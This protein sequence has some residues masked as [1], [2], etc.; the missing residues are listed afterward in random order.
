MQ[1]MLFDKGEPSD[2]PRDYIRKVGPD[3]YRQLAGGVPR[4]Y[5][6]WD[7]EFTGWAIVHC[8]H[9]T[10]NNPYYLHRSDVADSPASCRKFSKLDHAKAVS[11]RLW[12]ES[13]DAK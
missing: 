10:A 5:L 2:D 11:L 13:N 9:P 1:A 6:A 3:W 7:G 8:G 12:E 4:Y